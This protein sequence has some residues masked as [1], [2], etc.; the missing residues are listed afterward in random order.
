MSGAPSLSRPFLSPALLHCYF[1]PVSSTGANFV[2]EHRYPSPREASP[3]SRFG[4][5]PSSLNPGAVNL[6]RNGKETH[7]SARV[8]NQ[9]CR[10]FDTDDE[11]HTRIP[12]AWAVD[13]DEDYREMEDTAEVIGIS[14]AKS[15]FVDYC[16]R[17]AVWTEGFSNRLSVLFRLKVVV[18]V[19]VE[20]VGLVM[21]VRA[22]AVR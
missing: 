17:D 6:P 3:V 16:L 20:C 18:V 14:F 22:V 8:P 19:V 21:T 9:P 13:D 15:Y 7:G 12:Y 5:P 2:E 1:Y 11:V 4:A 10:A